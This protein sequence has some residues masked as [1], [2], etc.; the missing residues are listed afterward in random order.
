MTPSIVSYSSTKYYSNHILFC[1]INYAFVSRASAYSLAVFFDITKGAKNASAALVGLN[2]AL[3]IAFGALLSFGVNWVYHQLN[4]ANELAEK[5]DGIV[6]DYN[7]KISSL[8]SNQ[9]GFNELAQRYVELGKGV[10]DVGKNV[11][12]TTDEYEEYQTV[13]TKIADY[14]PNLVKGF[15]DSNVAIL[16][17]KDSVEALTGAYNDMIVAQYDSLLAT[18]GDVFQDFRNKSSSRENGSF[19]QTDIFGN[20][21]TVESRVYEILRSLI[22]STDLA[23]TWNDLNPSNADA[24]GLYNIIK[25]VVAPMAGESEADLVVRALRDV[26]LRPLLQSV[27]AQFDQETEA[28]ANGVSSIA[29]AYLE[30]RLATTE[31]DIPDAFKGIARSWLGDKGYDFYSSYADNEAGMYAEISR[32]IDI[33]S[34][35]PKDSPILAAFDIS[36]KFNG[37]ECAVED[38]LAAMSDARAAF[39]QLDPDTQAILEPQLDLDTSKLEQQYENMVNRLTNAFGG[40]KRGLIEELLGS[41]TGEEFEHLYSLDGEVL[42]TSLDEMKNSI[43]GV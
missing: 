20:E 37:Q 10:D 12:L 19:L 29:S 33:I 14:A 38:Y 35:I 43:T 13:V 8:T 17:V 42:D 22:N 23:Q 30:R 25:N 32:I 34:K 6:S 5:V 18:S 4:V 7:Q 9:N 2:S 16:T 3:N 41:L 24:R 31:A 28:L 27:I 1:Q 26:N 11:S 40:D 39:E 36:T 21:I 15:N